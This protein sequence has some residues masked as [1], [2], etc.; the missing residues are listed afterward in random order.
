MQ[1]TCVWQE[2]Q[3]EAVQEELPISEAPASSAAHPDP[4][5][6]ETLPLC[7]EEDTAAPSVDVASAGSKPDANTGSEAEAAKTTVVEAVQL[8][9]VGNPV[10][11]STW[12]KL[13]SKTDFSA[14]AAEATGSASS[15]S[16]NTASVFL[17]EDLCLY[18]WLG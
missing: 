10:P 15:G 1:C 9:H 2:M 6:P 5:I 18:Q 12:S 14:A 7:F 11:C 8:Q 13:G 16:G 4:E 17:V 3:D